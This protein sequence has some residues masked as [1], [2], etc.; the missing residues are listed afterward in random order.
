MP[1]RYATTTL[2]AVTVLGL[3]A[4]PALAASPMPNEVGGQQSVAAKAVSNVRISQ[5]GSRQI[6]VMFTPPTD[7]TGISRYR[8]QVFADNGAGKPGKSLGADSIDRNAAKSIDVS[9]RGSDT[10]EDTPIVVE[11]QGESMTVATTPVPSRTTLVGARAPEIT[12]RPISPDRRVVAVSWQDIATNPENQWSTSV[13]VQVSS[14]GGPWLDGTQVYGEQ[15]GDALAREIDRLSRSSRTV[16]LQLPHSGDHRVRI[17]IKQGA[18]E[19]PEGAGFGNWPA[20]K[21]LVWG[22]SPSFSTNASSGAIAAPS[23]LTL[24]AARAGTV[25]AAWS[26]APKASSY[27]VEVNAGEGWRTMAAQ[28]AK[29]KAI[30]KVAPRLKKG[31]R[32][33]VR[34]Q[35]QRHNVK[36]RYASTATKAR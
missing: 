17:G 30:K 36:S 19:L 11:V 28:T 33:K 8:A 10:S 23:G 2:V 3:T 26:K 24:Q 35:A 18:V 9:I 7:S 14:D 32:V 21:V 27:R 22:E 15:H 1:A 34:V 25:T 5:I 20:P 29:K 16:V 4:A 6:R 13:A 12:V 31:Q